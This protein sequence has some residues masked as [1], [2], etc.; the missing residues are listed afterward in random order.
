MLRMGV[1]ILWRKPQAWGA[2]IIHHLR[3]ASAVVQIAEHR[4]LVDPMFSEPG[5]LPSFRFL[6]RGGQR[7][8]IVPLPATSEAALEGV[9]GVLITHEHPD[10]LD[11][12][13]LAWIRDRGLPVWTN[14]VDAA[15]LR[16]KGL[17]V[18]ELVDG[19]L[20]MRIETVTNRHGRGLVGWLMGPVAGYYLAHPD[21]PSLY[22]VGDAVLTDAVLDAIDRLQPDV[23]V[24]P[25]GTAN[26]GLGDILFSVDELVTVARRAKGV[27]LLN[28]LEAVDHCRTT[29]LQLRARMA[30]EGLA[31]R[32][33][34]PEDG[35]ALRFDERT[36]TRPEPRLTATPRPGLQKWL[37]AKI[38]GT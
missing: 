19:A 13:G 12:P 29:R 32:V 25:A 4:L 27:L 7:N 2:M 35:E 22:L 9:S 14:A 28:H 3:N 11:R 18:R 15:N 20:G 16:R 37:T 23:I 30:A 8:P 1:V 21:E 31:D 36:G 34:V 33:F 5:S 38:A 6:A 24:A 26:F 17:E 10:H